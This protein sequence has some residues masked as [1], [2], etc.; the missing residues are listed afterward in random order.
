MSNDHYLVHLNH[1]LVEEFDILQVGVLAHVGHSIQEQGVVG[2]R[3]VDARKQIGYDAE[4]QRN[5]VR[6]KLRHVHIHYRPQHLRQPISSHTLFLKV[7]NFFVR[8]HLHSSTCYGSQ[9]HV[10]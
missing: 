4:K 7:T 2:L 5:V 10:S 9:R 1:F 3:Q 8:T 6:Q